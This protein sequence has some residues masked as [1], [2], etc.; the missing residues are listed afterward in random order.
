MPVTWL[1]ICAY[2][3]KPFREVPHLLGQIKCDY[4]WN[5]TRICFGE[6]KMGMLITGLRLGSRVRRHNN[7]D[8]QLSVH[9]TDNTAIIIIW[10]HL[11]E[12]K[13]T[14]S[15]WVPF[16]LTDIHELHEFIH[17]QSELQFTWLS[18][19]SIVSYN[20]L[21]A[22]E[23]HPFTSGSIKMGTYGYLNQQVSIIYLCTM[24][25]TALFSSRVQK[26]LPN[27]TVPIVQL[28]ISAIETII[29][30]LWIMKVKR[31]QMVLTYFW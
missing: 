15:Q 5:I 21:V 26:S 20:P 6:L 19:S 29:A 30:S 1:E 13:I 28:A 22:I 27:N 11:I 9:V 25:K 3:A 18:C 24:S 31:L 4:L 14:M 2:D 7:G 16:W 10:W 23:C 8:P 12:Q 17:T